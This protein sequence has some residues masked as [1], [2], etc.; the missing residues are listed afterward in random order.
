MTPGWM[1]IF[2]KLLSGE[3][4]NYPG[5]RA[6]AGA[7]WLF[8]S[9]TASAGYSL[10]SSTGSSLASSTGSSSASSGK[11]ASTEGS[12]YPGKRATGWAALAITIGAVASTSGAYT[13]CP[14]DSSSK[15]DGG[16]V[17]SITS[18]TWDTNCS[19][20]SAASLSFSCS[21]F[22]ASKAT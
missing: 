10:A 17:R 2:S 18:L 14:P 13:R 1:N 20:C 5:K 22:F 15:F 7:G 21:R 8:G 6:S 19:L 11:C 4:C 3:S 9:A 16:Q 12:T